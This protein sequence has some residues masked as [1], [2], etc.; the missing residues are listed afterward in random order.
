[1]KF[2]IQR[3]LWHKLLNQYLDTSFFKISDHSLIFP[4][5]INVNISRTGISQQLSQCSC[6][7]NGY[8]KFCMS[9]TESAPL[10]TQASISHY[11]YECHLPTYAQGRY[12][13]WHHLPTW[14][15]RLWQQEAQLPQRDSAS[16]THA[17]FGSLADRA[18]HWAPQL[19]Y[20]Y[21]ID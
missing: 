5:Y 17:F 14:Y 10:S 6:Q 1:M 7:C 19:F 8:V 2:K 15:A 11:W 3:V 16:A 9:V 18:L 12:K 20:N 21:I 13:S 4:V